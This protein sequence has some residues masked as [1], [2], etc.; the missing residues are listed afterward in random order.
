[1]NKPTVQ[2]VKF[3]LIVFLL[4]VYFLLLGLAALGLAGLAA[5]DGQI[6]LAALVLIFSCMF[7]YVARTLR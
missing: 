3:D 4:F 6:E 5:A 1:M 7:L 2:P